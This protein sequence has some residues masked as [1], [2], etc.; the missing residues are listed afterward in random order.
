MKNILD[1]KN[2]SKTFYA[3]ASSSDSSN[4]GSANSASN[5]AQTK[6]ASRRFL[7]FGTPSNQR[8]IC[9]LKGVSFA[10]QQGT[11]TGLVG[12][13]GCGKS[14]LARAI[15]KLISVD[16]GQIWLDGQDIVPLKDKDLVRVY[17]KVQ[18]VFQ[19]STSSFDPRKTLM[20]GISEQM[21]RSGASK[22]EA[23]Q[24]AREL[25]Q[26]C[27]L[28]PSLLNRYPHEVSGGQCQRAAIARALVTKPSL[29]ICDEATSALDAT[30][31]YQIV[32][33]LAALRDSQEITILFISHDLA[34]VSN[35]CSNM[36]VM[37]SGQIV[38]E[39]ATQQV[40]SNPHSSYTQQL[41]DAAL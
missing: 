5:K 12:Q 31:Q 11:C 6:G 34:L 20:S 27:G 33:L 14:T 19:N 7:P 38:E 10:I 28:E 18:M 41:L 24:T 1:I 21:I 8:A 17:E 16:E 15:C 23:L 13:S 29:L 39:G 9:A 22:Q 35:I 25:S 40:I 4:A 30:T 26:K 3:K 37:K 2:V 32:E 36:V